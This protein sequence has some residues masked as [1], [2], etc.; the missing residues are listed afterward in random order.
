ME[1]LGWLLA[2]WDP[3]LD[4]VPK[5]VLVVPDSILDLVP[6]LVLESWSQPEE[7]PELELKVLRFWW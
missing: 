7:V 2:V 5:L 6:R 4:L 3:I 1:P